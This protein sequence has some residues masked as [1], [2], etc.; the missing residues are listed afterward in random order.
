MLKRIFAPEQNSWFTDIAL[1]TLRLWL[2]LTMLFAHGL[3]K[4][5][6][7]S[8]MSGE[9]P[10]P[11]GVGHQVSLTLAVFGEVVCAALLAVGLVTR[12]AA[13]NLAATMSVAF[14]LVHRAALSGEG[15]GE[16][17]FIYLT[18]F[19]ALLLAGGG[20]FSIDALIFKKGK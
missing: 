17:A 9:F 18:G 11:L 16:M 20:R 3:V 12:F 4:L 10:D 1:L 14:F 19:V 7:Y 5:R 2:G 15:S 13:L 6:N 8:D